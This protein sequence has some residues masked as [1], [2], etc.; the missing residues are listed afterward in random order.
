MIFGG[1]DMILAIAASMISMEAKKI[2]QRG[3]TGLAVEIRPKKA[4]IS[5]GLD[6]VVKRV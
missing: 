3:R 4:C 1:L 5:K 2:K 6:I